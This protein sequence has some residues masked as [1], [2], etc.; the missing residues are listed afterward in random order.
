MGWQDWSCFRLISKALRD[1]QTT[2]YFSDI[3]TQVDGNFIFSLDNPH[4]RCFTF[5]KYCLVGKSWLNIFL[6]ICFR[7]FSLA[8]N[9]TQITSELLS[10]GGVRICHSHRQ[11]RP[12]EIWSL[13]LTFSVVEP[14]WLRTWAMAGLL[15]KA[16]TGKTDWLAPMYPDMWLAGWLAGWLID[17]PCSL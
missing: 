5:F 1:I 15:L 14:V 9:G 17:G 2:N 16:L 4:N 8:L 12:P 3:V 13:I 6:M 7:L 11:P 10:H